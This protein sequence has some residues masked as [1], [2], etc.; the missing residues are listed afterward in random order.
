MYGDFGS[1]PIAL[2]KSQYEVGRTYPFGI[3]PI[4][5]HADNK[6]IFINSLKMKL[7]LIIGFFHMGLGS[8]ISIAN[9]LYFKDKIT[10]ICQA[11]PQAIAFFSFLGISCVSLCLQMAGDNKPSIASQYAY[12]DVHRSIQY[13]ASNVPRPDA[14]PAIYILNNTNLHSM[15]D[16]QQANLLDI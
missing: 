3:D 8:A 6:M 10:L 4:W 14:R 2:F 16:T 13:E 5:H 1:L 11:V 15:D 7:S 12:L 9:S